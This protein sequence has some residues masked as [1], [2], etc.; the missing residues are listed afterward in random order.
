MAFYYF[1]ALLL[2][3][4]LHTFYYYFTALLPGASQILAFYYYFA[5]LQLHYFEKNLHKFWHFTT[6]LRLYY[7]GMLHTN[8]GIFCYYLL[9][10]HAS[11]KFSILLLFYGS[12]AFGKNFIA[13]VKCTF[14]H[15]WTSTQSYQKLNAPNQVLLNFWFYLCS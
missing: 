2:W 4:E 12:I 9:L 8:F 1:T 14:W 7:L 5:I 10:W 13:S 6:V 3:Q 11:H 15:F